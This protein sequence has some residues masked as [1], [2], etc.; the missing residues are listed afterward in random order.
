M[1]RSGSTAPVMAFSIGEEELSGLDVASFEGRVRFDE[2]LV[3]GEELVFA[4]GG[5]VAGPLA[6]R[7]VAGDFAALLGDLPAEG[8]DLAGVA[9]GYFFSSQEYPAL[10]LFVEPRGSRMR[11][12]DLHEGRLAGSVFANQRQHFALVYLQIHFVQRLH[13]GEGFGDFLHFQ[14]RV[15]KITA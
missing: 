14:K 13:A 7:I 2:G 5:K 11:V 6:P 8:S 9:G 15:H 1:W 4:L 3:E 12:E 10:V